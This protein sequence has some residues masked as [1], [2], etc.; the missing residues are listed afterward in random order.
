MATL[1][2]VHS[3]VVGGKSEDGS[4]V[5]SLVGAGTERNDPRQFRYI[6]VELVAPHLLRQVP[7]LPRGAVKKERAMRGRRDVV[8]YMWT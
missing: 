7:H 3:N 8:V 5:H 6:I 4:L 2:L 1:T